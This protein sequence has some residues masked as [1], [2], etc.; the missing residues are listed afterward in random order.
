MGL[1]SQDNSTDDKGLFSDPGD[2]PRKKYAKGKKSEP[3]F[4]SAALS[5]DTLQYAQTKIDVSRGKRGPLKAGFDPT[6]SLFAP[7]EPG[8][9]IETDRVASRISDEDTGNVASNTMDFL[10]GPELGLIGIAHDAESW[11]W[12][13]DNI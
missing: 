5:G 2:S 8:I 6:G 12:S 7:E 4:E 3:K 10:F 1:F 9:T 11:S 13:V